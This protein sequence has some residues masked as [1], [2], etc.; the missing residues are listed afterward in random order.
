MMWIPKQLQVPSESSIN[1]CSVNEFTQISVYIWI[2]SSDEDMQIKIKIY[3]LSLKIWAESQRQPQNE[4][5]LMQK[6]EL[7]SP[8]KQAEWS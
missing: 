7:L 5:N 3:L 4:A 2:E 6:K 8:E 1:I